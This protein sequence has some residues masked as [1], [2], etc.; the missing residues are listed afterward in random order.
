VLFGAI[1]FSQS[2]GFDSATIKVLTAPPD[3]TFPITPI[4]TTPNSLTMPSVSLAECIAWAYDVNNYQIT[5]AALPDDHYELIAKTT[6]RASKTQLQ[7]MLQTL[8]ASRFHLALHRDSK[9]LEIYAMS[10]GAKMQLEPAKDSGDMAIMPSPTDLTFTHVSMLS[11]AVLLSDRFE[12]AVMDQTGLKGEYN[13]KID[14]SPYFKGGLV[15]TG[16]LY[17]EGAVFYRAVQDQLGLKLERKKAAVDVLVI[18]H[19]EKP[20]AN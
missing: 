13:F 8:L 5:G 9:T 10:Q 7:A 1:A 17:G 2:R 16:D 3:R 19:V 6:A 20:T 15:D 14:I 18:D 11:L 4:R 12:R